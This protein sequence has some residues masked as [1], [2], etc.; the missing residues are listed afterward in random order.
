MNRQ[1]GPRECWKITPEIKFKII[2]VAFRNRD[3]SYEQM[4]KVLKHRWGVSVSINS[5][6]SV[7]REN[8]FI[9]ER[10]NKDD[11]WQQ[12]DLFDRGNREQLQ[13]DFFG[14]EEPQVPFLS[15]SSLDMDKRDGNDSYSKAKARSSYSK[16]QRIYLDQLE[17]GLYSAYA[18]GLLLIPLLEKYNYLPTIEREIGRAHV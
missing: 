3:I 13:M 10:T 2:E 16:A 8:G 6:R 5:I 15:L 18:G 4:V 11:L 9:E 12:G 17:Q 1:S 14:S 7:L